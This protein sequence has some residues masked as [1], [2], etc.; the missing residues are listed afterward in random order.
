M[1]RGMVKMSNKVFALDTEF[2]NL[3]NYVSLSENVSL[4]CEM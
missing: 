1:S 4:F 3:I 2:Q